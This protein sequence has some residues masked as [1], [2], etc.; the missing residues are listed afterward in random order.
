MVASTPPTA[1]RKCAVYAQDGPIVLSDCVIA[2]QCTTKED[3]AEVRS[4]LLSRWTEFSDIYGGTCAPY[5]TI[6]KLQDFLLRCGIV[7]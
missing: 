6:N 1:T 7:T 4:R 3:A 2:I 5:M